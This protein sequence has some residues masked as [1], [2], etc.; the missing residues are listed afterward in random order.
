[1]YR[2]CSGGLLQARRSR[3]TSLGALSLLTG[4]TG[5]QMGTASAESG[6]K[7]TVLETSMGITDNV[8]LLRHLALRFGDDDDFVEAHFGPGSKGE[9]SAALS[10]CAGRSSMGQKHEPS[11][12][13]LSVR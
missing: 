5:A 3:L 4:L 8:R 11:V 7:V 13:Q 12:V 10:S 1:M 9:Q 2:A 6:T